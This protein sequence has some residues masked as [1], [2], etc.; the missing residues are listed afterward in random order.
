M[1]Y[2]MV[3]FDLDGTILNTIGDL[4]SSVNVALEKYN[5]PL[6]DIDQTKAFLGSGVR[7]LV[8]LA[9]GVDESV[10]ELLNVFLEH[11]STHYN[12]STFPYEGIYD[13]IKFCHD[14][15]IKMGVLT[16]KVEDIAVGLC[17]AHFKD[18]FLFVYG[19]VLG[20]NRKPDPNMIF[21]IMRDYNIKN[22]EF[23]YVGDSEVDMKVSINANVNCV[24]MTY[25]FRKKEDLVSL[26]P[27]ALF[28]DRA[29]D[30][31]NYLK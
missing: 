11:Y 12:D 3:V 6:I 26:Y 22:D 1:K 9:S 19:D 25:G 21:K 5:L 20:R 31:L 28:A 17:D 8:S 29:V 10:D 16:N 24:L 2:K 18:D 23:L 4:C 30:L 13:V 15:G 27:D 7:R 14:N